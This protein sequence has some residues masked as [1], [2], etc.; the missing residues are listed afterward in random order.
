MNYELAQE[1]NYLTFPG[2]ADALDNLF[3]SASNDL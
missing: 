1:V 3:I 2:L